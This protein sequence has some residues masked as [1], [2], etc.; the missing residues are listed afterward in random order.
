MQN[1]VRWSLRFPD[2]ILWVKMDKKCDFL[3]F[4][5]KL[6]HK[7]MSNH[8]KLSNFHVLGVLHGVFTCAL[9]F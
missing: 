6:Q 7:S 4:A 1:R 9:S 3:K 8:G 5:Y 2:Y